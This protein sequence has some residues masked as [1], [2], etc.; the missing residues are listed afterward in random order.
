MA[1]EAKTDP[2]A[3][4]GT[5]AAGDTRLGDGEGLSKPAAA[6]SSSDQRASSAEAL[7]AKM[8]GGG[9]KPPAGN[10][11]N[12]GQ[13]PTANT[14]QVSADP[15]AALNLFA[16]GGND[17]GAA[18]VPSAKGVAGS[19]ENTDGLA[20]VEITLPEGVELLPEFREKL[21]TIA[22]DQKLGATQLQP[23]VDLYLS[24][25][26][27]RMKEAEEYFAQERSSLFAKA[28]ADPEIG[29]EKYQANRAAD[30]AFIQ[31]Y[32]TP[33]L[34]EL[35]KRDLAHQPE[36]MRLIQRIRGDFA[37]DSLETTNNAPAG[38]LT[39]EQRRDRMF[40]TSVGHTR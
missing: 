19:A 24:S 9:D 11:P 4:A 2:P 6:P 3:A 35:I 39:L 36:F 31:K 14:S 12:P 1:Q 37:E 27:D 34:V 22:R 28:K 25:E 5:P 38:K 23:L 26:Q 8:F 33:E 7:R 17:A 29:G 20:P 30:E 16:E 18:G 40:S 13:A 21:V 10:D 32:A 15:P